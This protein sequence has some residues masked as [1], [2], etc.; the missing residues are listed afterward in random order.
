MSPPMTKE[1]STLRFLW[2]WR[3]FD[4]YLYNK[5]YTCKNRQK[6]ICL[7]YHCRIAVLIFSSSWEETL[8]MIISVRIFCALYSEICSYIS[9]LKLSW[10]KVYYSTFVFIFNVCP[11]FIK[12]DMKILVLHLKKNSLSFFF[13]P[14]KRFC[15]Q[16]T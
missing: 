16:M 11:K 7:R 8:I 12:H 5:I 1:I 13:A 2:Y 10:C 15:E 6:P 9:L 14:S 4:F 3:Q